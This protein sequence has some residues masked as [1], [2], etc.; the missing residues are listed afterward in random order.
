MEVK[1]KEKLNDMAATLALQEMLRIIIGE[2]AF[3]PDRATF[4][5]NLRKIEE[6]AVNGLIGRTLFKDAAPEV[7]EYVKNVAASHVTKVIA[8]IRHPAD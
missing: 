4:R 1:D 5:A 2:L 3:N 6:T 8:S 7:D